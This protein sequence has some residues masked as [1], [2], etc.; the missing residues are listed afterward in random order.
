M[1]RFCSLL[2]ALT[3]IYSGIYA[4]TASPAAVIGPSSGKAAI[5]FFPL[6]ELKEGMKGTA[7]TVFRGS[8]PE[9]FGVEILGILPGGVGPRQDLIVGRIS[10]AN[11]ERTSVFAGNRGSV[12]FSICGRSIRT[13]QTGTLR[14]KGL[15]V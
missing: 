4:Q 1:A 3:L 13:I 15:P 9:E 10:G 11:V 12:L 2:L 7:R 8:E 6:S 14:R 5:P